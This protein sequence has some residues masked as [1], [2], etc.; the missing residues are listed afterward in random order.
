MKSTDSQE[1]VGTSN[2]E[3]L[4]SNSLL[5]TPHSS[6]GSQGIIKE[7]LPKLKDKC[8]DLFYDVK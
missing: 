8:L 2:V 4:S 5:L 1:K 6:L 7:D 3:F